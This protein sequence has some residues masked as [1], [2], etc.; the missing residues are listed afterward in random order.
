[1]FVTACPPLFVMSL[2]SYGFFRCWCF[3]VRVRL[4]AFLS[5][6]RRWPVSDG[7]VLI[8]RPTCGCAQNDEFSGSAPQRAG[9]SIASEFGM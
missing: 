7:P 9:R 1:M 6:G 2:R 8:F 5:V 3:V 4:C